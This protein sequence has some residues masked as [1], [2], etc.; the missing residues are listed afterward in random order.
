M[1]NVIF[2]GA[3]MQTT[4]K[5]DKELEQDIEIKLE[6][7]SFYRWHHWIRVFSIVILTLTGFYIATP[8]IAPTITAEPTNFL[9]AKL[10]AI[11]EIFGFVLISMFIAKGYYFFFSAKDKQE[12]RSFSDLFNVNKWIKQIGYYLFITKHPK[13][14]GAYNVIQLVAYLIFYIATA[15]L[16]LT[17]LILYIHNYHNGL[18]GLLYDIMRYFEVMFG[19]LAAVRQLH[20]ILTWGV[21][22]FVFGHIYMV[23]FNAIYS[24]EGTVDSIVSGYKWKRKE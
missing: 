4:K 1:G 7:T 16:I 9:Y 12:K 15:G 5:I 21:I 23:V 6:F 11:H 24:K 17:G 2:K 14:S 18:G 19:G 13:Q 20:H 22:L 8:F 10:R 3:V